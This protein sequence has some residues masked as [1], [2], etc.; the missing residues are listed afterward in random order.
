MATAQRPSAAAALYPNL[1][2]AERPEQQ[3]RAPSL[4]AAM[5]PALAK[6]EPN[7][8]DAWRGWFMHSIGLRKIAGGK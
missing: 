1:K 2:S 8:R 3:Q 7:P 4:S 6:P 5:Y